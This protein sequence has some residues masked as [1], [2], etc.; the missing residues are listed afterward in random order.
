SRFGGRSWL[1]GGNRAYCWLPAR[2]LAL[3]ALEAPLFDK[4]LCFGADVAMITI[5][6]L[7]LL[8]LVN[9]VPFR[10]DIDAARQAD[11]AAGLKRTRH[12]LVVTMGRSEQRCPP[13][14]LIRG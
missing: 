12:V 8:R 5:L 14:V 7:S 4:L 10:A 3:V 9:G 13:V 2:L 1:S 11:L 6:E